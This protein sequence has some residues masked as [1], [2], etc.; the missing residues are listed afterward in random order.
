MMQ[1]YR[2]ICCARAVT[3]CCFVFLAIGVVSLAGCS[4]MFYRQQT[5]AQ[6][7]ALVA[8]KDNDPRWMI[9]DFSITP[10][11]RSRF[12]EPTDAA[13]PPLTPDDPAAHQFME[14]V[15]GMR[16]SKKWDKLGYVDTIE[17]PT[18]RA[19]LDPQ[20]AAEGRPLSIRA[21]TAIGAIE[22]S[23]IH[24]RDYQ[25]RLENLYLAALSVSLER[26]QFDV[27]PTGILG[28]VGDLGE[29]GTTLFYQHQP[30]GQNSLALGPTNFGISKLFPTG[31]Q[32]VTELIND[33]VWL[34]AG[35]NSTNTAT[36]LSYSLI[37]PLLFAA[38]REIALENLTQA[39]RNLVY[40]LR[41]FARFRK[42]FFTSTITGGQVAGLQRFLRGFE[43]LA[44]GGSGPSVGFYPTLLRLQQVR[45]A[46]ENVRSVVAVI[47]EL[48]AQG[49]PAL[50]ITQMQGSLAGSQG[51][52]LSAQRLYDDRLDQYR[53]QLGLP[54]DVDLVLDDSLLA[55]FQ[56][57][58]ATVISADA[59]LQA[60]GRQIRLLPDPAPQAALGGVFE[61]LQQAAAGVG[62]AI[63]VA[64][65]DYQR[66][67]AVMPERLQT[68]SPQD[69]EPLVEVLR[70]DRAALEEA[71]GRF[72]QV[73]A[74]LAAL[75]QR[76][77]QPG[78]APAD[79]GALAGSASQVRNDLLQI[80]QA[81]S[82]TQAS[83]R[84]E[85][86]PLQLVEAEM[87]YET[88]LALDNRLDLM[89][90]R[91][92]VVDARRK[93]EVAANALEATV[94]LVA[95]GE[96]STP[97]LLGNGNPADFRARHSEFRIGVSVVTPLDRR[98]ER[99]NYRAAQIAY[100]RAR[101]VF[102][103][104]EDAIKLT[105]RQSVRT[106]EQLQ[107]S[108]EF[109]RQSVRSNARELYLAQT[110]E[111]GARG[112][113]L[114]RALFNIRRR[115]DSLILSWLDYESTRLNLARDTGTM[116]IDDRG[117]WVDP[118]YQ[119]MAQPAEAM[120]EALPEA[121]PEVLP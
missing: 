34:F 50:D 18:W 25:T 31:A 16:G 22:L 51:S 118:F 38:G 30:A 112:L 97:P 5:D 12:S 13:S 103:S 91:A 115:Q 21:L 27:R 85:L 72:S 11:P 67:D 53:V 121:L 77:G 47:D 117:I 55:P 6:V 86:I 107:A 28:D 80:V 99:N 98:A 39:E 110:R 43:F 82:Y 108:I 105:V 111:G 4:R 9:N 100:Q 17:N 35:P 116:Q 48:V 81:V 66:L 96:L 90:R 33:T 52:V 79:F 69:Q 87:I 46:Q 93:L 114:S 120:P 95:E 15:Y 64:R 32:F 41:D 78:L 109:D 113:D 23:H 57:V 58:D 1:R 76:A 84:V 102:M 49:A 40:A 75:Q 70:Q 14:V 37:Q 42:E 3:C 65:G 56:F 45:N 29:P 71:A 61:V 73:R 62:L 59:Q 60:I 119:Q 10:D 19:D 89:N 68:L 106:L 44:S 8:E 2:S 92:N 24:S 83:A 104:A 54:P 88:Q 7:Y 101:R 20:A 74:G 26:Y 36:T 63:E 94:D